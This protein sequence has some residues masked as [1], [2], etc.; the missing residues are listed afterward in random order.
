MFLTN[1]LKVIQMNDYLGWALGSDIPAT[2]VHLSGRDTEK[3]LERLYGIKKDDEEEE[4]T[5][6][7]P[8]D[9]PRCKVPNPPN[10]KFCGKCSAPLSL[11]VAME[12][13]DSKAYDKRELSVLLDDAEVRDLLIKKMVELNRV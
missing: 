9:C 12:M 10:N 4:L 6:L 8:V 7:K 2:Y 5:K 11:I 1:H 3:A 13:E